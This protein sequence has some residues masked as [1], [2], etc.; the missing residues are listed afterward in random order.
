MM[1]V[2]GALAFLTTYAYANEYQMGDTASVDVIVTV[3]DIC[4]LDRGEC[5]DV[6]V[7]ELTAAD[8]Q[9]APTP[10]EQRAQ[11]GEWRMIEELNEIEPAGGMK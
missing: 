9:A 1:N 10:E 11:L 2:M 8:I 4:S 7:E 6:V 5:A 3:V